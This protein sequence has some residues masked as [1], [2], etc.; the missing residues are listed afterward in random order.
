MSRY[1]NLSSP[2]LEALFVLLDDFKIGFDEQ[3]HRLDLFKGLNDHPCTAQIRKL[4]DRVPIFCVLAYHF[5]GKTGYGLWTR[6]DK[7]SGKEVLQAFSRIPLSTF[8]YVW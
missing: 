1:P 2:K 4:I 6:L 3:L 5:L 8:A 7:S